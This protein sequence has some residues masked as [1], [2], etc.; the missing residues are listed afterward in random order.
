MQIV[1]KLFTKEKLPKKEKSEAD[2]P[3]GN[4]KAVVL[5]DMDEMEFKQWEEDQVHGWA[6]FKRKIMKL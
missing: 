5:S 6:K 4:G 3:L 1:K 2:V